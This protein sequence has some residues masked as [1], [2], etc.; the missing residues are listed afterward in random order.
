MS[1]AVTTA[2]AARE[3]LA[4]ALGA[5]QSDP[6]VPPQLMAVSDPVAQAMGAL[7]QIERSG[8]A[9]V[10]QQAPAA[11]D[12]VRRALAML[13]AQ[14]SNH[15]A[16]ATALEAVAGSLGLVHGL[17]R[18][19]P[20]QPDPQP[21][22]PPAYAQQPAPQPYQAPPQ[23]PYQPPP[24]AAQ[25]APMQQ[26][27]APWQQQQP[28]Q[29]APQAQH[30]PPQAFQPSPQAQQYQPPP[31]QY[32]PPPQQ[33]QPPPQPAYQ[34]PAQV[35]PQ[36]QAY[37]HAPVAAPQARPAAA[38][39]IVAPA[40]AIRVEA[41]L[42][43]HSPSNFYK[44]L[45]GNDIIEHGGLFVATYNI[46]RIGQNVALHVS[47]PGGYE[48]EALGVVRWTRETVDSSV[49]GGAGGAH[50]GFGAQLTQVS[51]D[52]RQLVMRYVRNR[53]PLFHDDL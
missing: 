36:P 38:G 9:V 2:K 31:Q 35:A 34:S 50:P 48:F 52:A 29:P 39:P 21:V 11:L 33:F 27:A 43:T 37:A 41:E 6:G 42:G 49:G 15:P 51:Q 1:D 44:G 12:A 5:L 10:G 22:A 32:Q 20:T 26:Q 17:T 13:Q 30:Q 4:R 25:Q 7:F 47:L 53:E 8:G 24:Q 40:D 23:Q 14:P 28:A 16:V 45:S 19:P 46:P 18:V 3:S